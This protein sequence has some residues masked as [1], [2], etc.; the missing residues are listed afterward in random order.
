[1]PK[2]KAHP[3]QVSFDFEA[4]APASGIAA[5]AGL[6]RRICSTFGSVLASDQRS[7]SVIA[8]E[9]SDLLD[10]EI[11]V[12]M[13]NAYSSPAREA[14]RVPMSRFFALLV[15]TSRQDM[16][17]PLLREIGISGLLGDEVNTARLGQLQRIVAEAQA[18][19]RELKATAPKIRGSK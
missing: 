2:A 15:V 10:D 19:M 11:S 6:E 17:R 16:F 13:L 18:E 12:D 8:A 7:R 9:M 4:P 3:D 14:H 1:M 5:L